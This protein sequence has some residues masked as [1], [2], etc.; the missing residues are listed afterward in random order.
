[1]IPAHIRVISFVLSNTQVRILGVINK[2]ELMSPGY[3]FN[4]NVNKYD[5][6]RSSFDLLLARYISSRKQYPIVAVRDEEDGDQLKS[7]CLIHNY[8]FVECHKVVYVRHHGQ[9]ESGEE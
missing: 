1:M 2:L 8:L 7:A 5:I 6:T 4:P 3:M 9:S